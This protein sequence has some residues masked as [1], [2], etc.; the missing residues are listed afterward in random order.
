MEPVPFYSSKW[1]AVEDVVLRVI[2]QGGRWCITSPPSQEP[3]SKWVAGAHFGT[4]CDRR[5]FIA[6]AETFELAVCLA[7]LKAKGV[8]AEAKLRKEADH[9]S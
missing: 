9:E 6:S 5:S 4:W 3:G 7:A 1:A 2:Q 8:D